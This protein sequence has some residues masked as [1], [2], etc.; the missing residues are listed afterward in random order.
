MEEK[1]YR[2]GCEA[3]P[4][5]LLMI[6]GPTPV[7]QRILLAGAQPMIN[8]RGP[9]FK[10]ALEECTAGLK[11]I[12][13]TRHEL[14]ILTASGTGG[15]EAAV[16]NVLSPGDK[17]LSVSIG[18]FG[19]RFAAIASTY[20]AEVETL[21][22]PMG[23]AADP[24]QI[25]ERLAT[26]KSRGAAPCPER[27]RGKQ[28][29]RPLGSLVRGGSRPLT[30]GQNNGVLPVR[31]PEVKAVLVTQNETSTGV[32]N[33]MK[34]IGAV[35]RAHGALLL[36]DGISSLVAMDCQMDAWNIDVLVAGSQKAF[37][38]PPGLCFI[39]VSDRAQAAMADAKM[40]RF[41]FDLGAAKRYLQQGETP[42]TPAVPQ[43]LQLREALKLLEK[44]GLQNCFARHARLAKA[45]REGVKALGLK[46]LADEAV[47]SNAVTSVR[48]PDGVDV[49]ALRK[50]L[51]EKYGV[52]L[53]G[54]Q[55]SLKNDIFR[56]GHL[57]LVSETDIIAVLGV[58][59]IALKQL[60]VKVDPGAGAAA[61]VAALGKG[62]DSPRRT[63]QPSAG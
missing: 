37:M 34:A 32:M 33:D 46:L 38:I 8:H 13:Q 26:D 63:P 16:V 51:R 45:T 58:L 62:C 12:F 10:A 41:Y 31:T 36:V 14:Y 2:G 48:K 42:W 15:L 29:P 11:R 21:N 7:P 17:V 35:V 18:V 61:A 24:K 20:G 5:Q 9:E 25:A 30:A 44:E 1:Q 40:P 60:G 19:D 55:G 52:V 3:T 54:G 6:P 53:A 22:F 49:A 43:V 39:A 50:L 47:A 59:G 56:I 4:H 57:G 28:P 27:S 23:T